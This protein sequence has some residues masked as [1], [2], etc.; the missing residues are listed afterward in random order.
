MESSYIANNYAGTLYYG[1]PV[2]AK[3][4]IIAKHFLLEFTMTII[5][6]M[7]WSGYLSY[8]CGKDSSYYNLK[9]LPGMVFTT[10]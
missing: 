8:T 4:C 7:H 1:M 3:N 6:H 9:S 5:C 2:G 10:H